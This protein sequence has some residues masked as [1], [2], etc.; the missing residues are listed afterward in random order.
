MTAN[1]AI[2]MPM[3]RSL[4]SFASRARVVVGRCLFWFIRAAWD[5]N[6][7]RAAASVEHANFLKRAMESTKRTHDALMGL[8]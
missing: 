6:A 8:D 1:W 2:I 5:D 7:R 3:T 4:H